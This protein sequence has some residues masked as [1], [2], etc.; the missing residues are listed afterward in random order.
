M[1]KTRCLTPGSHS[2][3]SLVYH[4]RLILGT[5]QMNVGTNGTG[6]SH[7]HPRRL[8]SILRFHLSGTTHHAPRS[9]S[10]R[11]SGLF[12]KFTNVFAGPARGRP[13]LVA[14][15]FN[16]LYRRFAIGRATDICGRVGPACVR[17]NAILRYGR[18]KIC[19]TRLPA[20][21]GCVYE[22]EP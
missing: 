2:G 3:Q 10:P 12:R 5:V 11:R 19:A 15:I 7:R 17:Q 1:S 21:R 18:L 4:N 9:P 14:Q 16:L 13:L 8:G 22:K 6:D 20:L